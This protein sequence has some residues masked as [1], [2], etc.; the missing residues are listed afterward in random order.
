[1]GVRN[2]PFPV[3][4]AGGN[5]QQYV[6][7]SFERIRRIRLVRQKYLKDTDCSEERFSK[8]LK[9]KPNDLK[10]IESG[11]EKQTPLEVFQNC[12]K[13]L[14][15]SVDHLISNKILWEDQFVEPIMFCPQIGSVMHAIRAQLASD[16]ESNWRDYS[17]KSVAVK[18]GISSMDLKRIEEMNWSNHFENRELFKKLAEVYNLSVADFQ[19]LYETSF[20][21]GDERREAVSRDNDQV[22]YIKENG[23]I[24]GIIVLKDDLGTDDF[25]QLHERIKLDVDFLRSKSSRKH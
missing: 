22:R 13:I 16:K 14:G 2:L 15:V 20:P 9:I 1:M 25:A 11:R 7:P 5:M 10:K 17:L 24:K 12:S 6:E 3:V 4:Q 8:L 21:R 19:D 23:V 18:L